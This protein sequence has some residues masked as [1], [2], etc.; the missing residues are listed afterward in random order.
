M[1]SNEKKNDYFLN[2]GQVVKNAIDNLIGF[3]KSRLDP[4]ITPKLEDEPIQQFIRS[5]IGLYSHKANILEPEDED[6]DEENTRFGSVDPNELIRQGRERTLKQILGPDATLEQKNPKTPEEQEE[7]QM[8]R[9]ILEQGQKQALE[10]IIPEQEQRTGLLSRIP[11]INRIGRGGRGILDMDENI[12]EVLKMLTNIKY[13]IDLFEAEKITLD[14]KDIDK[15][16]K[17]EIE[18]LIEDIGPEQLNINQKLINGFIY[19]LQHSIEEILFGNSFE[20]NNYLIPIMFYKTIFDYKKHI[21]ERIRQGNSVGMSSSLRNFLPLL[22]D[23]LG[24]I[25]DIVGEKNYNQISALRDKP[26]ELISKL[27][28]KFSE[29]SNLANDTE[30]LIYS[31]FFSKLE[32]LKKVCENIL[33]KQ[34]NII[35]KYS[36]YISETSAL[37]C[38]NNDIKVCLENLGLEIITNITN[39]TKIQKVETNLQDPTLKTLLTYASLISKNIKTPSV[40][41]SKKDIQDITSDKIKNLYTNDSIYYQLVDF[42]ETIS[43]SVRVYLRTKDYISGIGDIKNFSNANQIDYDKDNGITKNY[44]DNTITFDKDDIIVDHLTYGPFYKI[45]NTGTTNENI[46]KEKMIDMENIVNM[47]KMVD[48]ADDGSKRNIVF[49][50]YGLSGS[51]KTFTLFGTK[52][53]NDGIWS[54]MNNE[55]KNAG[56]TSTYIGCTKVYGKFTNKDFA[57]KMDMT[58]YDKQNFETFLN[59]QIF[60]VADVTN[61][62]AFIK[63]TPNNKAS[64]RGFLIASFEIKK[65]TKSLGKF[66]MVDMAGNE[67]PYDL[68]VK[69]LP[70]LKWPQLNN[71]SNINDKNFINEESSLVDIDFT[72]EALFESYMNTHTNILDIIYGI[73]GFINRFTGFTPAVKTQI[74]EGIKGKLLNNLGT[75]GENEYSLLTE[76]KNFSELIQKQIYLFIKADAY[77]WIHDLVVQLKQIPVFKADLKADLNPR[78]GYFIHLLEDIQKKFK[79]LTNKD[80]IYFKLLQNNFNF[81]LSEGDIRSMSKIAKPIFLD[82]KVKLMRFEQTLTALQMIY[83]T[84][85]K[86]INNTTKKINNENPELMSTLLNDVNELLSTYDPIDFI[87][88][89]NNTNPTVDFEGCKIDYETMK[90]SWRN[91]NKGAPFTQDCFKNRLIQLEVKKQYCDKDKFTVKFDGEKEYKNYTECLVDKIDTVIYKCMKIDDKKK[92]LSVLKLVSLI[93]YKYN[94]LIPQIVSC[95]IEIKSMSDLKEQFEFRID[96]K[97]IKSPTI[98]TDYTTPDNIK[99][100]FRTEFKTHVNN[101]LK[102]L[103]RKIPIDGVDIEFSTD[104]LLRIIQEGFYINQANKELVTYLKKKQNIGEMEDKTDCK[105]DINNLY[106]ENYNKFDNIYGKTNENCK[107]TGLTDELDTQFPSNDLE[108][109]KYIMICNLRREKDI[110]VRLG[111]VD[112]LKL[113]EELKST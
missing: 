36:S 68:M 44:S 84:I 41:P 26:E 75:I 94:T 99:N 20:E 106:F 113:V 111:T 87:S 2:Q 8:R 57:K 9:S 35:D 55:L 72:Y 95:P 43:G 47:F 69:L 13:M 107:I 52:G 90:L 5:K 105:L 56:L 53:N 42:Y 65:G 25:K 10:K 85:E 38:E 112:T 73:F 34:D 71:A 62:D 101:Y 93:K 4:T 37:H 49:F 63:S 45:I 51:G 12:I 96:L 61:A 76:P 97:D 66:G 79:E 110:K 58:P 48:S 21:I 88:Y 80:R 108:Q 91:F 83:Y 30:T 86:E 104:Y 16:N 3:F 19:Y 24:T 100:K 89:K 27:T 92:I 33:K 15:L 98:S 11:L 74:E 7:E 46:I 81:I 31:Q 14:G 18:T 59:N 109:T 1:S 54:V 64:S 60:V 22:V 82:I 70:T 23:F 67:D 32:N 28:K 29:L 17:D 103:K 39:S 102:T 50:T 77:T 78:S 40:N 6:E